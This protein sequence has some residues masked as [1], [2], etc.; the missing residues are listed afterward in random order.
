MSKTLLQGAPHPREVGERRA[1]YLDA[2]GLEPGVLAEGS[3][4]GGL[5]CPVLHQLH[6]DDVCGILLLKHLHSLLQMVLPAEPARGRDC[7]EK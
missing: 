6:E 4:H 7:K 3:Q 1:S 2:A 5:G